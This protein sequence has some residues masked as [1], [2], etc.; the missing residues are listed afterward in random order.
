MGF[1]VSELRVGGDREERGEWRGE[2]RRHHEI[3]ILKS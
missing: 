3:R 2:W 1:G